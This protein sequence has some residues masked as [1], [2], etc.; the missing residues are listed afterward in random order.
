[1]SMP[2]FTTTR[3]APF[4]EGGGRPTR[5]AQRAEKRDR[6][7][8]PENGVNPS[9]HEHQEA[10]S[11]AKDTNRSRSR[12]QGNSPATEQDWPNCGQ[13]EDTCP[14]KAIR[15]PVQAREVNPGPAQ[16]RGRHGYGKQYP[17]KRRTA[18]CPGVNC[19]KRELT[20]YRRMPGN[21]P[22][23]SR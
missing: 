14:K 22:V 21:Q 20:P 17:K 16:G 6:R 8:T 9:T 4:M 7:K 10:E 5:T 11:S 18:S 2:P 13:Q 1:M 23:I 3:E 15:R 12:N 19:H